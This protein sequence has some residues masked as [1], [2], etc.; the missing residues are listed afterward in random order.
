MLGFRERSEKD[1]RRRTLWQQQLGADSEHILKPLAACFIT[2]SSFQ[3]YLVVG[4]YVEPCIELL[5]S[6][7][8]HSFCN[9]FEN[10]LCDLCE[11]DVRLRLIQC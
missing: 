1:I 6:C 8:G 9:E 4:S 3:L 7:V 10:L 2:S 11:I 5:V